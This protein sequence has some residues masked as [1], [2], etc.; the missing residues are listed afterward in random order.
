MKLPKDITRRDRPTGGS[1]PSVHKNSGS[2][3]RIDRPMPIALH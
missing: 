1:C 3:I 2:M